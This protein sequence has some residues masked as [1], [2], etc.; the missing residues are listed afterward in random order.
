MERRGRGRGGACNAAWE[1]GSGSGGSEGGT[2]EGRQ[3]REVLLISEDGGESEDMDGY[4]Q[5]C[6]VHCVTFTKSVAFRPLAG[7]GRALRGEEEMMDTRANNNSGCC[8]HSDQY[9]VFHHCS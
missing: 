6:G 5:C 4:G 3:E 7:G 1:P 2:K 8:G 9:I